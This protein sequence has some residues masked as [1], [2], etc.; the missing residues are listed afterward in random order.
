MIGRDL[1]FE[2]TEPPQAG[3]EPVLTLDQLSCKGDT[4]ASALKAVSLVVRRHEIVGIA[5]VDG[6]GQRELAECVAGLRT[7]GGA[8]HVDGCRPVD[9]LQ[10]P[11]TLGFMPEDRHE[12]GLVG[13]FSVAENLMLRSHGREPFCHRGLMRWPT[14]RRHAVEQIRRYNIKAPGPDLP[15]KLLSGGNQ[16]KVI[17]ARE[18][19]PRPAVLVAAH[20]TRGLDVG[21]VEGVLQDLR[22][23][24]A[25]GAGV[26]LISTELPELLVVCDRI[27]VM[28]RGEIMGEVA[29]TS[30]N[31][32]DIAAMMMGRRIQPTDTADA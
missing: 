3:G 18:A 13:D 29:P 27:V 12:Q 30:D 31:I 14:I 20:P 26:L 10:D 4:T 28:H 8:I 15:V 25:A 21:A 23:S 32:D 11:K 22:E 16:Q 7:Y 2:R 19:S 6:N 9:A 17:V 24:R 1:V 5:G